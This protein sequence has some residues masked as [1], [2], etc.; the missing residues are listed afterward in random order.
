MKT[1][2]SMMVA[3]AL[4][5]G[6]VVSTTFASADARSSDAVA[7]GDGSVSRIG[8]GS[9][10]VMQTSPN[11]RHTSIAWVRKGALNITHLDSRGR[12]M[13]TT[14]T[15]RAAPAY[16][17]PDCIFVDDLG[18]TTVI[19]DTTS[20]YKARVMLARFGPDSVLTQPKYITKSGN[21]TD[22][23]L[24]GRPSGELLAQWDI[25][26]DSNPWGYLRPRLREVMPIA[27]DGEVGESQTISKRNKLGIARIAY[28]QGGQAFI[29]HDDRDSIT[30]SKLSSTGKPESSRY[31]TKS[32]WLDIYDVIPLGKDGVMVV[33]TTFK[34]IFESSIVLTTINASGNIEKTR[35]FREVSSGSK[36]ALRLL[37]V[38]PQT[39]GSARIA[40]S[41]FRYIPLFSRTSICGLCTRKVRTM[42]ARIS[43]TGRPGRSS[44]IFRS[45]GD[46]LRVRTTPPQIRISRATFPGA[47]GRTT[48]FGAQRMDQNHWRIVFARSA[49]HRTRA[50]PL[51]RR[52]R[53]D[54]PDVSTATTAS[55]VAIAVWQEG[56]FGGAIRLAR[57]P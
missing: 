7:V 12:V 44:S 18:V 11:G 26:Y 50:V 49:H 15:N 21:I 57:I 24:A 10:P 52:F 53:T 25:Q 38:E 22:I 20:T 6:A 42:Q 16:V 47:G 55:R 34:D 27:T 3:I 35:K 45:A 17:D 41:E 32:K 43:P 37:S 29:V 48:L 8:T 46:F 5:F 36:K 56:S 39:D 28:S 14:R 2:F 33:S 4:T 13:S 31:I 40:W 54:S 30:V 23:S 9:Y 19:W 51:S 1:R